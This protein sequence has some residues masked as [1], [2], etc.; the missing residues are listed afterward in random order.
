MFARLKG[1]S[2]NLVA[3]GAL[4]IALVAVYVLRNHSNIQQ[5]WRGI[6]LA[7]IVISFFAGLFNYW[8]LLKISEAPISSIAAA[9]QGYIELQGIASTEKP[10]KTPYHGIPCVWYRAW[11]Y[12]NI[13]ANGKSTGIYET[14]LLDYSESQTVFTLSDSTGQCSVDPKGAEIMHFKASTWRKNNHRYAE[15]Y[16]PAGKPLY[17]L[18]QLDTRHDTLDDATA[19][20]NI[21]QK[22]AQLKA[23]P[24]HLLNRY[25]HNLD[26]KIS[27]EEWELA[28]HDA[29]KEV[30]GEHAMRKN[31]GDFTLAKPNDKHLFLISAQS[32]QTLRDNYKYWVASHLCILG[33]LT[34]LLIKF[35]KLY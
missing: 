7:C 24:Q 16:L 8:R 30:H 27:L 28:R 15:Q 12:A 5:I 3:I 6:L 9:A 19:R 17:V 22:L 34:F 33:L 18:G 4:M 32:P 20:K 25:D 14:R 10:I 35:S 31:L 11:V 1:H 23:R 21:S 29:I 13:E 2:V 26:G